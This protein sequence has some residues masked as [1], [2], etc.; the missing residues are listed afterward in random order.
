MLREAEVNKWLNKW[1]GSTTRSPYHPDYQDAHNYF[2]SLPTDMSLPE[3][4]LLLHKEFPNAKRFTMN[5]WIR[6]W[7]GTKS[8]K[9]H[10]AYSDAYNFYLSLPADML[11]S[12]KR[13]LMIENFPISNEIRFGLGLINGNLTIVLF[14]QHARQKNREK[15]MRCSYLYHPIFLSKK[16][17]RYFIM[18][19]QTL[20][21]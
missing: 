17:V 6:Q 5:K 4:R 8:L 12:E 16:G 11:L 9:R 15:D 3:K 21:P 19:F 7:S 14:K 13:R 10:P 1:S 20:N 18:N 2:L